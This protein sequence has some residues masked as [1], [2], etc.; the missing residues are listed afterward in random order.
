MSIDQIRKSLDKNVRAPAS[1]FA[2]LDKKGND[3]MTIKETNHLISNFK[4]MANALTLQ[5]HEVRQR[6]ALLGQRVEER[7]DAL[8]KSEQHFRAFVEN[9]NDVLFV[10]TPSGDFSYVSPR[11]KEAFGYEISETL[12]Q[13]FRLFVH[14][15]DDPTCAAFLQQILATGEKQS[16]LEYRVLRKDGTYLWYTA[17]AAR[18]TDPVDGSH[19]LVGIGRDI[20]GRKRAEEQLQRSLEEKTVLLK[21]IHHR[22]KNNMTVVY[23]LLNLQAQKVTDPTCRAMFDESRNRVMSMALIHEKLYGSK[24]LAHVDYKEYLKSLVAGIAETYKRDNV[25]VSVAME[26]LA[27]DVNVGIPCGLIVNELVSNCLKYAFPVGRKGTITVGINNDSAGNN[28]MT[29]EDNGVGF[30]ETVDFRN[31]TSLGLQLVNALSGQI[32]GSIELSKV[33]GTKFSITF[34]GSKNNF[35]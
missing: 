9:A 18:V 17:N 32:N 19:T 33:E 10:L 24:D 22:V 21:E 3:I 14:P 4:E 26:P 23:S 29:V 31:T 28:V 15:D 11:W 6:N 7:T 20:T 8:Q 12:G 5:F 16:G 1:L 27:L 34:P 13:P 35:F 2:I 25:V 30:P